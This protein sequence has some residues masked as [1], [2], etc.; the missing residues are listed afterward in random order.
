MH[1]SDKKIHCTYPHCFF[2][3]TS[4]SSFKHEMLKG[5]AAKGIEVRG[6]IAADVAQEYI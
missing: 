1:L 5:W 2:G 3:N 4:Y 6:G